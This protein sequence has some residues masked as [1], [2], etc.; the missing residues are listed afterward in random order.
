MAKNEE[1][2][3][4]WGAGDSSNLTVTWE[5]WLVYLKKIINKKLFRQAM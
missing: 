5:M 2:F 4:F 3:S 1:T